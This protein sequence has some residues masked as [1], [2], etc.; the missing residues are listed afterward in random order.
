MR[1]VLSAYRSCQMPL[2]E[3][4]HVFE[5]SVSLV[6]FKND[7]LPSGNTFGAS[8]KRAGFGVIGPDQVLGC[9]S[10]QL[11]PLAKPQRLTTHAA[12]LDTRW[13]M[14]ADRVGFAG[15][16]T[17]RAIRAD[18]FRIGGPSGTNL[19]ENKALILAQGPVAAWTI[20]RSPPYS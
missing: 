8:S 18:M 1:R 14:N 20:H 5:Q 2:S 19:N 12:H 3:L 9:E 4:A 11:D 15:W 17:G 16:L 10:H 6:P 7:W 13:R